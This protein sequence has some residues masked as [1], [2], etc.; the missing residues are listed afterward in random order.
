[1]DDSDLTEAER[2]EIER[3]QDALADPA[4][5]TEPPPHLQEAVVAAI[6]EEAG[7]VRRRSRVRFAVAGVAAAV[8]LAVGVTIGVQLTR[9]DPVEF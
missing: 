3:V 7:S 9:A 8:L 6:A 2:A 5:W 4:V 1:M